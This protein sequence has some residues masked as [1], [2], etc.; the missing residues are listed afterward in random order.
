[1]LTD[2]ETGHV[3]GVDTAISELRADSC[4]LRIIP[5]AHT[6]VI[7]VGGI[8]MVAMREFRLDQTH[9]PQIATR[10]HRPHVAYEAVA[11]VAII[12]RADK[13]RFAGQPDDCLSLGH[14]H[15]HGFF[16]KNVKARL[17]VRLCDLKM[18]RIGRRD[19]DQVDAIIAACFTLQHFAP[20]T[21]GAVSG[22][23]EPLTIRAPLVGSM[24]QC[25]RSEREQAVEACANTVRGADLAALTPADH[26]PV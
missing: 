26:A 4:L 9:L 20:I 5:P 16:T 17:E 2:H 15:R 13:S 18:R 19:G 12:D 22:K 11:R 8:G 10:N 23:S 6:R 14:G 7:G 25:A 1:M 21:I 24:I 3:Q